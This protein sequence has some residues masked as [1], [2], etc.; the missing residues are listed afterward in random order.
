[1]II[2]TIYPQRLNPKLEVLP[3]TNNGTYEPWFGIDGFSKVIV[4]VPVYDYATK[5][6]E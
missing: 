1:M 2:N 5:E 6:V 4:S 3:V